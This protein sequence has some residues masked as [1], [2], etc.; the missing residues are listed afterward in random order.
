M[1]SCSE[2]GLP[3]R[4]LAPRCG[5]DG[6][7]TVATDRDLLIGRRIGPYTIEQRLGEGGYAV[8]YRVSGDRG[9]AALKLLLGEMACL[10]L[11]A[12]RFRREA[13]AM[14]RID[15]PNVA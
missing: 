13:L 15:H 14:R 5:L 2:C 11:L 3:Y 12:E 7:P 9:E 4:S 6:A 10:P 1:R 8:L